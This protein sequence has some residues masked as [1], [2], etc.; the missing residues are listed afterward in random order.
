MA[1]GHLLRLVQTLLAIWSGLV[2]SQVLAQ[3]ISKAM[4]NT[5]YALHATID[6]PENFLV[7]A[8][9]G[10]REPKSLLIR[11]YGPSNW[12]FDRNDEQAIALALAKENIIPKWYGTFGNGRIEQFILSDTLTSAQIRSYSNDFAAKVFKKLHL[13]H[14]SLPTVLE[15]TDNF[16]L[17][18]YLW[19]RLDSWREKAIGAFNILVQNEERTELVEA[20]RTWDVF[21][22]ENIKSLKQVALTAASPLV[23][24]HADVPLV[25]NHSIIPCLAS[26]WKCVVSTWDRGT[27]S[28][29]L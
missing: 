14:A 3:R 26:S 23:I 20:I 15:T 18:D 10:E 4:S 21:N 24:A 12:M 25:L 29:R 11:I 6:A 17:K 7:N 13:I 8:E 22:V 2:C 5:V 16:S 28:H 27:C 9:T 1:A 19:D